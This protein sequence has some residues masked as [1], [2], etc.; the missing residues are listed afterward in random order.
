LYN[1]AVNYR[2]LLAC[3][4]VAAGCDKT[5]TVTRVVNLHVTAACPVPGGSYGQY[6]ATGDYAPAARSALIPT[7]QPGPTIDG[8]PAD[9]QSLALLATPPDDSQWLGVTLVPPSGD[10]DMLL[11][12]A[13]S[14]CALNAKVGFAD[15][16]VFGA[17][18]AG[19]MIATGAVVNA[20]QQPKTYLVNLDTGRVGAMQVG[21]HHARLHA[22]I[23]PFGDAGQVLV[24]AGVTASTPVPLEDAE[25]YDPATGDIDPK[26]IDHVDARQDFA[27]VT[28]ASGDVLLVGGRSAAGPVL[29][30]E[31][32]VYDADSANWTTTTAGMPVL[33]SGGRTNPYALR[34]ADGTVLVGGGFDDAGVAVPGVL[35]FGPDAATSLAPTSVPA[36][37]KHAFVALEGGGAL[38]VTAPEAGDPSDF[39]RAWFVTPGASTP[40]VPDVTTELDDVKL[41][42]HAGGGALLWTGKK[43]LVFDPWTGFAPLAPSPASGPD[44]ASPVAAAGPGLRAWVGLDGTVSVW[45]DSARNA[46]AT[47]DPYLT[48]ASRT[49]MLAPDAWPPP[50]FDPTLGLALQ[51]GRTVFVADA[52]YLDVAVDVDSSSGG[53]PL[54]V[55]RS[56][57]AEVEVG[58]ASCPYPPTSASH[59]HVERRGAFVSYSLGGP[60]SPCATLAS[61]AR[62]AVGVRGA[63]GTSHALNFSVTRLTPALH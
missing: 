17:A 52:R 36:R 45:R 62:V 56:P 26:V 43:W 31:R 20:T 23:A 9:V 13:A 18:S 6:V 27:A 54:V 25:V 46:F 42:A 55:L 33:E 5:E 10:L 1:V 38:F 57:N 47:D 16:M 50:P 63:G 40:I 61:D 35:F 60:L 53:P 15:G 28:L 14:A 41:F 12:P 11:L 29:G 39:Q 8:I 21:L 32:V 51:P 34:L 44:A 49:A 48:P 22:G 4:A 37:S 59:V 58:G 30:C 7:D 3:I 2:A 19:A 24:A